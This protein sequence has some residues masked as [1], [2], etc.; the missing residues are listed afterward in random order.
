MAQSAYALQLL[1]LLLLFLATPLI[2][3]TPAA[4]DRSSFP[5]DFVFGAASSAY[6]VE[7]SWNSDG[8]GPSIWD[9][10]THTQP[11]KIADGK[12][13]DVA[14]DFYHRYK[15]DVKLLK[16]LNMDAFRFSISWT[17][18][19]PTG[20]LRGGINRKGVEF[21]NNLI[22]EL[23]AHGMRPYVTIF[24]WDTPQGLESKYG[25]FLSRNIVDDY[26]DFAEVCFKE[27]GDRVKHWITFNEPYSYCSRAYDLGTFAPG[28][29]SPWVGNCTAGDSG[30]EPYIACHNI[31]LAHA[32]TVKVYKEKYQVNTIINTLI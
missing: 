28:R 24:H 18:I 10:F 17:R 23:L 32:A 29:C 21:Y 31:I 15:D 27:F 6:Q 3:V 14:I 16:S 26:R 30:R 19:L 7:G 20:S 11:W 13:G 2:S 8:K 12:T 9:T 1:L 22:D 4:F 5:S 25:G